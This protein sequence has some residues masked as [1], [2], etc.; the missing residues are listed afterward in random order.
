MFNTANRSAGVAVKFSPAVKN[1]PPPVTFT[2]CIIL[3]V[4]RAELILGR[5]FTYR[6]RI[7]VTVLQYQFIKVR[8]KYINV[9]MDAHGQ[10][11]VGSWFR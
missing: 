11:P 6:I 9:P 8:I 10:L 1:Y 4:Y 5:Y 2:V 7:P 3:C